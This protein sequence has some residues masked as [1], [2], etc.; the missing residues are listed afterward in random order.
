MVLQ[1]LKSGYEALKSAL[2]KTRSQFSDRLRTLFSRK[3]NVELLDELEE[4]FYEADLGVKTAQELTKKTKDFL[5]KNPDATADTVLSFM[6]SELA[7][8]LEPFDYS[9]KTAHTSPTVIL[10]VGTNGNGKTTFIAKLARRLIDEGKSVLLAAGDT[11]RAGAQEQLKVWAERLNI[12]MISGNYMGDPAA[13]V[14]DAIQ[15]A[16]ARGCDYLL[17][18]TAGRLENKTNLMKELEKIK[19]SC[20]KFIPE[21]PHETLLVLDA[22]IGQNGL[23]YAKTFSEFTPLTGLVL[24]K[25][26]GTAKGGTAIAIQKE[27]GIPIKF[28]GTGEGIHDLAPFD[29]KVFVHALFFE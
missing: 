23:Q 28:V 11:F 27:V 22:T 26:D 3:F 10:V 9:L 25:M 21:S 2:K 24:T 12:E 16:K 29:P 18:D 19:R 5:K 4:I 17:I 1:F 14:F 20:Q 6:E 8:T 7:D 15:A 13:V